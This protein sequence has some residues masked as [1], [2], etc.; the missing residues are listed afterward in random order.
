MKR[1]L[2]IS[3]NL[4]GDA[5]N[6][7]PA[8]RAWHAGHQDWKISLL[9]LPDQVAPLYYRMGVPLTVVTED[10]KAEFDFIFNFHCG[11]AFD[12][13]QRFGMHITQCYGQMLGVEIESRC[14][15]YEPLEEDHEVD[16]VLVSLFSKSCS[17]QKGG[18]PPN[19]MLPWDKAAKLIEM[20]RQLGKIGILAAD[21]DD[22]VP[23]FKDSRYNI[24]ENEYYRGLSLNKV[25]LM[26]R[27]CKMLL[28]I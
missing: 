17:S 20:L 5:L 3:K 23:I 16:L 15:V 8:L 1:A 25:A 4:I 14:P 22:R 2:F 26:L 24:I 18:Q 10:Q 21:N 9:T 7:S 6:I 13:G 19:K 11:Q 28:T 12:L 27:D